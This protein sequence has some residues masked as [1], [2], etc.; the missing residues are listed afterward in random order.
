MAQVAF[1]QDTHF[2]YADYARWPESERW[3]LVDGEAYAMAAPQRLHQK[4]VLA[5]GAQLYQYL[6]GK[7][8]EPYVAPFD[9]RLPKA[10]EADDAI[11][12]VVQPDIVVVCDPTKLDDKGC[13][14]A[15]DWII[16]VL[17]PSTALMDMMKKLNLYQKHG[18]KE[19][20]LVHPTDQW[21]MIYVLE[22]NGE[23]GKPQVLGMTEPSP[24]GLFPGLLLDWTFLLPPPVGN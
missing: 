7:P 12:T 24:V 19:Y 13:R 17:S 15:P 20:W 5:I 3:E 8:C 23:Y 9:V 11:D 18:V 1:K 16:E 21:I 14:G 10:S 2:T 4:V 6:Q 22:S